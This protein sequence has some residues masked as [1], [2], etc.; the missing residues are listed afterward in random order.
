MIH[1]GIGDNRSAIR[2]S[3]EDDR[4]THEVEDTRDVQASEDTP[5]NGLAGA[6]A[7]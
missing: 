7:G 4:A 3:D 1:R 6:S 2:M 5:R